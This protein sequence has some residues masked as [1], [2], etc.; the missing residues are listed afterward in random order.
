MSL[1]A[2]LIFGVIS[3]YGAYNMSNDPKDI[4]FSLCEYC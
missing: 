1:V 3:A 4:K 2:G